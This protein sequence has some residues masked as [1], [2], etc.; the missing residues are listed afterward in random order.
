MQQATLS[1][2]LLAMAILGVA[3][4][5]QAAAQS[6]ANRV[7][8]GLQTYVEAG[9]SAH[10]SRRVAVGVRLPWD[11]QAQRWGG[12]FTAN[13][14][15]GIAYWRTDVT[16]GVH[17]SVT[18]QLRW[19][20]SDGASPWFVEGGIGLSWHDKPYEDSSARM[21]TR[22][23]FYDVIGVGRSFG[24]ERRQEVTLRLAHISNAGLAHPNPGAEL[25][26]LRYAT[27]F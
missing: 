3:T 11:W 18:P 17:L 7:V 22:W 5:G 25:L 16:S 1:P 12:Q 15:F 9:A 8:D 4:C 6:V 20:P 14:D 2:A 26:M 24:V 13:T 21:S 10:D 19:R 27:R 23:N